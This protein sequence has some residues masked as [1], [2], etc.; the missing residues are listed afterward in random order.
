M[1]VLS[2]PVPSAHRDGPPPAAL[3]SAVAA[4]Y[5]GIAGQT[6][7]NWRSL[8]EG[9]LTS[10]SDRSPGVESSTALVILTN[11]SRPT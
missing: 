1:P 2:S 10:D 8:G 9:P 11:F 4:N 3:T 7:S 6:L 5:M